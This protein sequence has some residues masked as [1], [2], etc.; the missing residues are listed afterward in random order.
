MI[1]QKP[2]KLVLIAAA[3]IKHGKSLRIRLAEVT[4][5]T[6]RKFLTIAGLRRL[7]PL[8][9]KTLYKILKSHDYEKSSGVMRDTLLKIL[10]E[11]LS[12]SICHIK[13]PTL[14]FWAAATPMCPWPTA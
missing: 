8:A 6:G 1:S 5:K 9:Q 13:N 12:G 7:A 14:I 3:G 10:D 4:A 11:D 2:D